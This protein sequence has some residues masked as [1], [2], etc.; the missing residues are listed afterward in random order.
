MPEEEEDWASLREKEGS[1]L[2]AGIHSVAPPW[3]PLAA[4]FGSPTRPFASNPAT[5]GS[6]LAQG[7]S[8]VRLTPNLHQPSRCAATQ[9]GN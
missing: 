8:L 3:D 7:Q 2:I 9:Q 5:G 6:H 1:W 4:L